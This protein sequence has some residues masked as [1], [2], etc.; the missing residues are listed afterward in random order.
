M[1]SDKTRAYERLHLHK[2]SGVRHKLYNEAIVIEIVIPEGHIC[3]L[4]NIIKILL[5]V[6]ASSAKYSIDKV[7]EPTTERA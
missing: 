5:R 2:R 3:V 1:S 4:G 6:N 7:Q